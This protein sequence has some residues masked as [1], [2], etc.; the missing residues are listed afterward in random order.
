M[1]RLS[2]YCCSFLVICAEYAFLN[3]QAFSLASEASLTP[4]PSALKYTALEPQ[5]QPLLAGAA[6]AVLPALRSPREILT[7]FTVGTILLLDLQQKL[8]HLLHPDHLLQS[9][10]SPPPFDPLEDQSTNEAKVNILTGMKEQGPDGEKRFLLDYVHR[11]EKHLR[12]TLIYYHGLENEEI[13]DLEEFAVFEEPSQSEKE[14][15]ILLYLFVSTLRQEIEERQKVYKNTK[16]LEK[17]QEM[18]EASI[19]KT[20]MILIKKNDTQGNPS[21]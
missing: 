6:G 4:E 9:H 8:H 19:L 16:S 17:W 1:T 18:V 3:P 7:L 14:T 11:D 12:N 20:R 21:S 13:Q 15:A 2:L 10:T 5:H